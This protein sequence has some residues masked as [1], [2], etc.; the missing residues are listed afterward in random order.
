MTA[1]TTI[2]LRLEVYTRRLGSRRPR[3]GSGAG[4][5]CSLQK[6]SGGQSDNHR[7]YG[8]QYSTVGA[9]LAA[10][11]APYQAPATACDRRVSYVGAWEE[12]G[13]VPALS[14]LVA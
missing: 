11:L 6:E 10:A 13:S 8:L 1:V 5:H 12:A 2:W 7:G 4:H 14:A 9:A 3:C